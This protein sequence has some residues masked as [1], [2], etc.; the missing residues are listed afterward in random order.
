MLYQEHGMVP[1]SCHIGVRC[2]SPFT[3]MLA[4]ITFMYVWLV[5]I[6][7]EGATGE[8]PSSSIIVPTNCR[9]CCEA[10][11]RPL[12]INQSHACDCLFLCLFIHSFPSIGSCI[13]KVIDPCGW[14]TWRY[15][16]RCSS[17]SERKV[18]VQSFWHWER[19]GGSS[20]KYMDLRE[21]GV[22]SLCE[23]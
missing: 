15:P 16:L 13:S 8:V 6:R 20:S 23:F 5:D 19:V 17:A 14:V 3:G 4:V 1:F 7:Q 21:L 18:P 10:H 9:T 22:S 11:W 12:N 2:T